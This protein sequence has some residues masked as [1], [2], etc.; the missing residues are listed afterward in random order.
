MGIACI[1][2]YVEWNKL[3]AKEELKF[4]YNAWTVYKQSIRNLNVSLM[5]FYQDLI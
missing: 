4:K 3:R 2:K 1:Q 5:N